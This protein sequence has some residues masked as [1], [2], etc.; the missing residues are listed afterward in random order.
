LVFRGRYQ[1]GFDA[2]I[3]RKPPVPEQIWTELVDVGFQNAD[4]KAAPKMAAIISAKWKIK[5]PFSE[6]AGLEVI[7]AFARANAI[8]EAKSL[9]KE[10]TALKAS[11]SIELDRGEAELDVWAH[12]F[13]AAG[14]ILARIDKPSGRR[15]ALS[16]S[17]FHERM[18]GAYAVADREDDAKAM[19]EKCA[20]KRGDFLTIELIGCE[21][22][23]GHADAA[24]EL[25]NRFQP[26]LRLNGLRTLA[27]GWAQAKETAGLGQWI[28]SLTSPE[29][30]AY[31][32]MGIAEG[33]L[34][35]H[36]RD[37]FDGPN[38]W[39]HPL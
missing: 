5:P 19:W 11:R 26:A 32:A 4:R 3:R 20:S 25:L 6:E 37:P 33:L 8:P 36:L 7:F 28:D 9:C 14:E 18:V 27:E 24:Q 15:T 16:A 39:P 34:H 17:D 23:A 10:M 1:D 13:T 35:T 22:R 2:S 12:D 29:E 30:K 21:A 31:A 38:M